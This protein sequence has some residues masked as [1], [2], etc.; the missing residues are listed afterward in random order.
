MLLTNCFR[1]DVD[2]FLEVHVISL[3]VR[4]CKKQILR[5]K[6]IIII[7]L[8]NKTVYQKT[9]ILLCIYN[10]A[11]IGIQKGVSY[12]PSYY[13][14]N[15]FLDPRAKKQKEKRMTEKHLETGYKSRY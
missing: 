15:S 13:T 8:Q 2:F 12:L 14:P 5:K 1:D 7:K 4:I 11:N 9:L 6:N 3:F 10:V